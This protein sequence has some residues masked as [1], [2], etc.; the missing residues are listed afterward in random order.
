MKNFLK[1]YQSTTRSKRKLL[2]REKDRL[3][4]SL[5]DSNFGIIFPPC[6][7]PA[8]TTVKRTMKIMVRLGLAS[9]STLTI[10]GLS[11]NKVLGEPVLTRTVVKVCL[12]PVPLVI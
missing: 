5:A 8:L 2:K 11:T 12:A 6:P 9:F 1:N 10:R 7:Y 3:R 4:H